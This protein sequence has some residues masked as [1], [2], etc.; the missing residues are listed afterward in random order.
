MEVNHISNQITDTTD[1]AL[2][3]VGNNSITVQGIMANQ[4]SADDFLF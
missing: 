3:A 1:G 4:L 2:I